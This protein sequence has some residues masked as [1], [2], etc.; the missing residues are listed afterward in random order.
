MSWGEGGNGVGVTLV[1]ECICSPCSSASLSSRSGFGVRI[2]RCR[3]IRA[4]VVRIL[5]ESFARA[6]QARMSP[7][8]HSRL[9][10]PRARMSHWVCIRARRVR[11]PRRHG[12]PARH[13]ALRVHS[14]RPHILRLPR[15][16]TPTPCCG[17]WVPGCWILVSVVV[18]FGWGWV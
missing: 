15:T 7:C 4:L 18:N 10:A 5:R 1:A 9:R 8:P 13:R 12:V 16:R 11:V 3:Y 2:P 17:G 6:L 14:P